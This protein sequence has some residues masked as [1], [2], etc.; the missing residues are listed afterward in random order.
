M[1]NLFVGVVM[2][3]VAVLV[4]ARSSR[5]EPPPATEPRKVGEVLAALKAT[6]APPETL[7]AVRW[8]AEV[9]RGTVV[10]AP[11]GS[12]ADTLGPWSDNGPLLDAERAL[13]D[14]AP[15]QPARAGQRLPPPGSSKLKHRW[16]LHRRRRRAHLPQAGGRQSPAARA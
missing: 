3:A 12:P 9:T 4:L 15:L 14:C 11:V 8:Y 6:K 7:S 5:A 2:V 16:S 1:R 13:G 10:E